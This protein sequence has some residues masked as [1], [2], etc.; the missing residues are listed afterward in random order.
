MCLIQQ[1]IT[2]SWDTFKEPFKWTWMIYHLPQSAAYMH[3]WISSALVQIMVCRPFGAKPLSK[4]MLVFINWTRSNKLQWNFNQT[5]KFFF[6]ENVSE[7]IVCEM[8]AILSRG[9]WVKSPAIRCNQG[10]IHWP[11]DQK[12]VFLEI[13]LAGLDTGSGGGLNINMPFCKYMNSHYK[14]KTVRPS[15]L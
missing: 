15:Y 1:W 11:L 3:Q 12:M 2:H 10:S 9:R 6:H 13:I 8:A 7:Y 4:S 5:T 14:D